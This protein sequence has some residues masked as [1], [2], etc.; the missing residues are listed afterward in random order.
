[1]TTRK[2]FAAQYAGRLRQAALVYEIK[3]SAG[4][5]TASQDA[6]TTVRQV[7]KEIAELRYESGALLE[8]E[9]VDGLLVDIDAELDLEPG[10]MAW[11]K[12]GSVKA[13]LQQNQMV[14]QLMQALS[15]KK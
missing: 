6:G 8:P 4:T 10:T 3:E 14:T 13:L 9:D 7:L 12:E 2:E 15:G 5:K 11:I 1:M